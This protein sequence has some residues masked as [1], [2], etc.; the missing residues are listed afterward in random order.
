[1]TS[2]TM[3]VDVSQDWM[4]AC[5]VQ[6]RFMHGLDRALDS[7]D[8]SARCRQRQ[9]LGGDCYEFVPLGDQRLAV[10][11]GDASGKGLPAA[12]MITNVHPSLRTAASPRG[13]D[14][15]AVLEAVNRQVYASSLTNQYATLFYGVIDGA[16]RTLQYANAGHNPPMAI[17]RD[18]SVVWLAAGGAPIGMFPDSIYEAGD[19][20]LYPGHLV[21]AYT[22]GVIEAAN[23]AGEE[24]GTES[25]KRAGS[26]GDAHSADEIVSA[27]FASMDGF[28]QGRQTDDATVA[29]SRVCSD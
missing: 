24:W 17:R 11:I 15:A 29:V 12:L 5:D 2:D 14:L 27:I 18:G 16:A 28:S 10:T 7:L 20:R 9:A 19:V 6:E 26:E 22:D 1:M 25:L 8:Y 3:V 23:S 21:L 4:I 13:N